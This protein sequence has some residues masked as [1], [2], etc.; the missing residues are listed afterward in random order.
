MRILILT[1]Y[2]QPESASNAILMTLLAEELTHLGHEVTVITGM[3]HY[4]TNRIQEPYRGRLLA[5]EQQGAIRVHR[6]YLYVPQRKD[7]VLGRLLNYLSFNALSTL[8]GLSVRR[9]DVLFVP[10]PPLTNGVAGF[11]LSRLRRMPFI[12]NVQDIY[13]DVAVRLGVLKSR[14]VIRLFERM[15]GF[16][17]RKASAISVIS[18]SFRRNLGAKG[19]PD[20]KLRVIPN[21]VDSDFVTP[22]PRLNAFSKEQGLDDHFVALFS[23]NVGMSQGLDT[24]LEAAQRL[25]DTPDILFLI[26]GN[27]T[28]KPGL[29]ERAATMG[30]QNVRFLPFQPYERVPELYATADVCL[31]P[32][33]R[34]LSEDSVPSK[35][36]TIMGSARPVVAAVDRESDTAEVVTRAGCGDCVEPEDACQMAEAILRFYRDRARGQALGA[37][38]REFVLAHY[39][40]EQVAK[41]YA[42]LFAEVSGKSPADGEPGL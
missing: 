9:Q 12:Y 6:V 40:R 31:I 41:Q 33:R 38:G 21:F 32:L 3:P 19:V 16:V 30:L 23:G 5:R 8:A 10:S 2:F 29:I 1:T 14:R 4:D 18:E 13:P 15:E 27:G 22:L 20:G 34:G 26:V 25:A 35:L 11:V 28:T 42:A 36:F 24:V 7:K 17:Y 37:Q 39:T